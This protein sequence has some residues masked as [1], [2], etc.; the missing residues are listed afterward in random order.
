MFIVLVGCLVCWM[1]HCL[2][3]KKMVHWKD[4]GW[5]NGWIVGWLP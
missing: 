5:L 2:D 4:V 3:D 1:V